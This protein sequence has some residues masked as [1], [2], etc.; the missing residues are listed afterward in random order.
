MIVCR[1]DNMKLMVAAGVRNNYIIP[2]VGIYTRRN[3]D[4]YKEKYLS[5]TSTQVI[6]ILMIII[7]GPYSRNKL[8]TTIKSSLMHIDIQTDFNEKPPNIYVSR[9]TLWNTDLSIW[10]FRQHFRL[11]PETSRIQLS[12]TRFMQ[13][14]IR[15]RPLFAKWMLFLI[16]EIG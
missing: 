11:F 10:Y 14:C 4:T 7:L 8:K 5:G 3:Q 6:V 16:C 13:G 12:S 1:Q 9:F 15:K 2:D